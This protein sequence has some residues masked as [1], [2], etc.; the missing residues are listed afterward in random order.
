[1]NFVSRA[2]SEGG[3]L[4]G[5]EAMVVWGGVVT[6]LDLTQRPSP[7]LDLTPRG[8][9]PTQPTSP[10][11]SS[12]V[13]RAVS[14][15]F[16]K[17]MRFLVS[18]SRLLA[19]TR[20]TKVSNAFGSTRCPSCWLNSNPPPPRGVCL[21]TVR[22]LSFGNAGLRLREG[23]QGQH[24]RVPLGPYGIGTE[25]SQH[26]RRSTMPLSR[27]ASRRC[28]LGGGREHHGGPD[29]PALGEEHPRPG[30]RAPQLNEARVRGARRGHPDVPNLLHGDVVSLSCRP[31]VGHEQSSSSSAPRLVEQ[32]EQTADALEAQ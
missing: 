24:V 27:G 15:A 25:H 28:V 9:G 5:P 16:A 18:V 1:M 12:E 23:Q 7:G 11:C 17:V 31:R 3:S 29:F 6:W 20:C 13:G 19:R 14:G 26:G 30:P 32:L 22:L 2:C 21:D 4:A 10:G 8:L